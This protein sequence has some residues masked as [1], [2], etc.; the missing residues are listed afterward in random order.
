MFTLV[1]LYNG[2]MGD[3]CFLL[4]CVIKT[5]HDEEIFK[6]ETKWNNVKNKKVR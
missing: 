5:V 2:N 4:N 1:I 3:F 6:W